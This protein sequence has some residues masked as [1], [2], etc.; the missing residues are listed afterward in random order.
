MV[1]RL[2][3]PAHWLLCLVSMLAIAGA[4][5]IS[6]AQSPGSDEGG[7]GRNA[8]V[9]T[10]ADERILD[11]VCRFEI[12]RD[13]SVVITETIRLVAAGKQIKHGIYRD[14]PLRQDNQ[15]GGLRRVD[16]KLLETKRDG[17]PDA[18]HAVIRGNF[19]RVY[20]GRKDYFLP[21]G[22]HTYTIKYRL[23]PWVLPHV[24][25]HIVLWEATGASWPFPIEQASATVVAPPGTRL[26][27]GSANTGAPAKRTASYTKRLI[28][29]RTMSFR[30]TKP[31]RPGENLFF[32][33]LFTKHPSRIPPWRK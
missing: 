24:D 33:V 18:N 32:L 16:A 15:E 4:A 13:D 30:A 29:P 17:K 25:N 5:G 14:L 26:L 7:N 3:A 11:F 28:G 12:A 20:V 19:M 21:H 27:T 10:R 8:A 6:G 22:A 1:Q 2:L 31:L 9:G 23:S